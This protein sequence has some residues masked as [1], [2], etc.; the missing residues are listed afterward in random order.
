MLRRWLRDLWLKHTEKKALTPEVR[1]MLVDLDGVYEQRDLHESRPPAAS[2][3]SLPRDAQ[4]PVQNP[5]PQLASRQAPSMVRP[6]AEI[7]TDGRS[8]NRGPLL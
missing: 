2:E 3:Q 7:G 5:L 8:P 6:D 4:A 1:N